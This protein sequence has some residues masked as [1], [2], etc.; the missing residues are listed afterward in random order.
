L[1]SLIHE[2]A[3]ESAV[4]RFLNEEKGKYGEN[5]LFIFKKPLIRGKVGY[6]FELKS[7]IIGY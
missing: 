3:E 1:K 6:S 4:F 2:T 5:A 7:L